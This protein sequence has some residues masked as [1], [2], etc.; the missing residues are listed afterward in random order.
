MNKLKIICSMFII[1]V[2]F[3]SVYSRSVTAA[4]ILFGNDEGFN[5]FNNGVRGICSSNPDINNNKNSTILY[6]DS[7]EE[8]NHFN[9]LKTAVNKSKAGDIIYLEPGIYK[10]PGN[11]NITISHDLTIIGINT[12]KIGIDVNNTKDERYTNNTYFSSDVIFD[13]QNKNSFLTI[14]NNVNVTLLNLTFTNGTTNS[15]GGAIINHGILTIDRTSFSNNSVF[16]A[17]DNNSDDWYNQDPNN[18]DDLANLSHSNQNFGGAIYSTNQLKITNSNFDYNIAGK[19]CKG[20]A[21]FN[22]GDLDINNTLFKANFASDGGGAIYIT[23]GK[24]SINQSTFELNIASTD[25]KS[26]GG[27]GIFSYNTDINVDNTIFMSNIAIG[28]CGGAINDK[29]SSLTLDNTYFIHNVAD[30]SDGGAIYSLKNYETS[31]NGSLF[32]MNNATADGGAIYHKASKSYEIQNSVLINNTAN[33]GGA[34]YFGDSENIQISASSLLNNSVSSTGGA[35]YNNN[36]NVNLVNDE[37]STNNAVRGGAVYSERGSLNIKGSILRDNSASSNG[38]ALYSS[39]DKMKIKD[40]Y[41][42]NNSAVNNGGAFYL[43]GNFNKIDSSTFAVNHVFQNG[44]AIYSTNSVD[45]HNSNFK[46]NMACEDGGVIWS[47]DTP[48]LKSNSYEKNMAGKY[49]GVLLSNKDKPSEGSCSFKEDFAGYGGDNYYTQE[50]KD[51][52]PGI[53]TGVF[54]AWLIILIGLTIAALLSGLAL[55][56]AL[57]DYLAISAG[58]A[59]AI[60]IAIGIG[61]ACGLIAAGLIFLSDYLFDLCPEF[62]KFNERNPLVQ[63]LITIGVVICVM[64][65]YFYALSMDFTEPLKAIAQGAAAAST[66]SANM[67]SGI[68]MHLDDYV[69]AAVFVAKGTV[70]AIDNEYNQGGVKPPDGS[71]DDSQVSKMES[72][73]KRISFDYNGTQINLGDYIISDYNTTSYDINSGISEFIFLATPPKKIQEKNY[74]ILHCKGTYNTETYFMT[75]DFFTSIDYDSSSLVYSW[76][77]P[78]SDLMRYE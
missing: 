48:S 49:G 19:H 9:D 43:T 67:L 27:G 57:I 13:G 12:N 56:K 10:G 34:S 74:P 30:G 28:S 73:F 35:I 61:L 54:I 41:L 31:I 60:G 47:G 63:S 2:L 55:A 78:Y 50:D 17:T 45:V 42:I 46:A 77:G 29:G 53:I 37:I 18:I 1:F 7:S 51:L 22:N 65:C 14:N 11:S 39:T 16:Q 4:D 52:V 59:A 66:G 8:K 33:C 6:V 38:G 40:N 24:L 3:L 76:K 5:I 15:S 62:K 70:G 23:D 75:I 21:I 69:T 32:L 36:A 58:T 44:G 72:F 68:L 64:A 71:Q 26:S 25:S 20:G